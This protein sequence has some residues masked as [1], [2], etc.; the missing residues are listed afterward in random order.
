MAVN[1]IERYVNDNYP[2]IA[3]LNKNGSLVD[4]TNSTVSLVI[5]KPTGDELIA[6][7][8]T[9]PLSGE[10]KFEVTSANMS[11]A[12]TYKYKITVVDSAQYTTTYAVA[13]LILL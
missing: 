3:I 4:L 5:Q 6:G 13:K 10:V 1:D 2:I 9:T 11:P 12:G 7:I 8:I